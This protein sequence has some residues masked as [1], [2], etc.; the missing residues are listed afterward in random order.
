MKAVGK[1]YKFTRRGK[2]LI[3]YFA[4]D[5]NYNFATKEFVITVV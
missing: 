2:Y 4:K 5:E 3:R 1:T